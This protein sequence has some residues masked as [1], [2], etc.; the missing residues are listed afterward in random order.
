[1]LSYPD[2]MGYARTARCHSSNLL[3]EWCQNCESLDL[4]LTTTLWP[5]RSNGVYTQ[6]NAISFGV[7][8]TICSC[9]LVTDVLHRFF[10]VHCEQGNEMI[11]GYIRE[12]KMCPKNRKKLTNEQPTKL[13]IVMPL[14]V[15]LYWFTIAWIKVITS[16]GKFM[17]F[18]NGVLTP[19]ILQLERLMLN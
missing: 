8:I 11:M 4:F 3:N 14:T 2:T 16:K 10:I 15:W 12:S 13:P 19:R 1:M 9:Y 7:N 5:N 17:P 18:R 6:F